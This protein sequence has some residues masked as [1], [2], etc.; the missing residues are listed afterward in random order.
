MNQEPGLNDGD[1]PRPWQPRFGLGSM[2]LVMLVFAVMAAAGSYF[3]RALDGQREFRPTFIIFTLVAPVALLV[4]LSFL[5]WIWI[6][7]RSR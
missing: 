5:R 3:V 2:L 4:V 1:A 6:L 7:V